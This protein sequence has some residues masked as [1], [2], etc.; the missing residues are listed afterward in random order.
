ME[1]L[2][3]K[4]MQEQAEELSKLSPEITQ[5]PA[6]RKTILPQ[7]VRLVYPGENAAYSWPNRGDVD[8]PRTLMQ[9]RELS[10]YVSP[11]GKKFQVSRIATP[12]EVPGHE[13]K[14]E[15]GEIMDVGLSEEG[16]LTF[17]DSTGRLTT[18]N[19]PQKK[20]LSTDYSYKQF[21]K[22][23]NEIVRSD[24][25]KTTYVDRQYGVKIG[26]HIGDH[27][28]KFTKWD[29]EEQ[30]YAF[31]GDL[32][33]ARHISREM[34]NPVVNY[35]KTTKGPVRIGS[36]HVNFDDTFAYASYN[37]EHPEYFPVEFASLGFSSKSVPSE[38]IR[39]YNSTPEQCQAF[40]EKVKFLYQ[41]A[42]EQ[43]LIKTEDPELEETA[44]KSR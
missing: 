15:Q 20:N 44:G 35:V 4:F 17:T 21:D 37:G 9:P 23:G 2:E 38:F 40:D 1:N 13:Y 29:I 30:N 10:I 3:E 39:T 12:H 14:E 5:N 8:N 28:P 41:K 26:T 19:D 43:G 27:R 32:K 31:Y 24:F 11:D 34:A 33:F 18:E 16:D 36:R 7:L 42:V 22:K 25:V 6:F